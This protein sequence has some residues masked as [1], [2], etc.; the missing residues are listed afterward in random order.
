MRP[1]LFVDIDGVINI[2][3]PARKGK[4]FAN[5][6]HR[7]HWTHW[8]KKEFPIVEN[9]ETVMYPFIHSPEMLES[10]LSLQDHLDIVWLTTWEEETQGLLRELTGLPSLPYLAKS[11]GRDDYLSNYTEGFWWKVVALGKEIDSNPRPFLWLEDI[12]STELRK[13]VRD[14]AQ[15][16]SVQ[17]DVLRSYEAVGITKAMLEQVKVFAS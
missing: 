10:L 12:Y 6:K 2:F 3:P 7:N 13:Q 17:G 11:G 4:S 5:G 1:V 8:E 14:I 16:N 9:G 15:R